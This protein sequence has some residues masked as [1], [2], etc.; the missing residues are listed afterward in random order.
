MIR[1]GYETDK[2]QPVNIIYMHRHEF[3]DIFPLLLIFKIIATFLVEHIF[4]K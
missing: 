1:R 4:C 2:Q 3:I